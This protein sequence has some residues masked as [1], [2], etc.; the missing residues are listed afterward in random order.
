MAVSKGTRPKI[1]IINDDRSL[2]NSRRMLL[3]DCG[4]EV[5]TARGVEEAVRETLHDPV[6]LV[7]IDV[8]NVGL[9]HGVMLCDLVKSIHPSQCV[10]L[11]VTPE[12]GLPSSSRADRVIFRTGP[13]KIL[14]EINEMLDG[15]LDLNLWN[16][17]GQ[18]NQDENEDSASGE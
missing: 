3:E 2:L 4:A 5:F 16:T 7:V 9:E 1:L 18:R 17:R 6:E 11:L 14:V 10:A 12:M 13:R 15:C 8:T